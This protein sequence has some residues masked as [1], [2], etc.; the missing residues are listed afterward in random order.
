MPP[1]RIDEERKSK[2][3]LSFGFDC[4]KRAEGGKIAKEMANKVVRLLPFL[5]FEWKFGGA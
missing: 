4:M 1:K 5:G 2:M 3:F